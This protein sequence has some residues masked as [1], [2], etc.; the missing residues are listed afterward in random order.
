MDDQ[1]LLCKIEALG[2]MFPWPGLSIIQS[3]SIEEYQSSDGMRYGTILHN[4]TWNAIEVPWK[5]EIDGEGIRNKVF[6]YGLLP[7]PILG[8]FKVI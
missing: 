8:D 3:I 5:R 2:N 6:F 1:I 4:V 7:Y